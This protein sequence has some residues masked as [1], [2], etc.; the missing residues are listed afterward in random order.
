MNEKSHL[1]HPTKMPCPTFDLGVIQSGCY[2]HC[3]YGQKGICYAKNN[4]HE[5]MPRRK[6][7]LNRNNKLIKSAR[8]VRTLSMEILAKSTSHFRFFSSGDFPNIEAFV[9]VM[10]LCKATPNVSYW[11]PTT[12]EDLLSKY[13]IEDKNVIPPNVCIRLSNAMVDTPTPQ[14]MKDFW[15]KY[16]VTFSE[17]SSNKNN[18]TCHA[19]LGKNGNCGLCRSCWNRNHKVTVYKIHGKTAVMKMKKLMVKI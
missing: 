17:T 18:A 13:L 3:D 9:K 6:R 12:R 15:Y 7:L 1:S 4:P 2:K 5:Y 11:I 10:D 16:G 19:S 14:F 8:F